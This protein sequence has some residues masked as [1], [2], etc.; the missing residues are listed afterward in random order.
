MVKTRFARLGMLAVGLGIGAAWAHNPVAAADSSSDWL[1]SI[2][3]LLTGALPAA[4]PSGL[5]LAISFDGMSLLQ[6]GNASA[7][8]VSGEY[9]LAIAYG[10]GASATAEGGTGNY[11]LAD[12]TNAEAAAG[13]A[14]GSTG[15]NFNS[16]IDIGNNG[17]AVSVGNLNGAYA[18]AGSLLGN[19]GGTGGGSFNTAIDIGNNASGTF[20]DGAHAGAG[21]LAG[22]GD[23][24][25]HDFAIDFGNN[26]SGSFQGAE[27]LGGDY[28]SGSYFGNIDVADGSNG[29]F[30]YAGFGDG[31]IANV[32]GDNSYAFSGG[33]FDP[34]VVGNDNIATVFDPFGTLGSTAVAG[35]GFDIPGNFDLAAVFGDGFDTFPGATGGNFLVEILPTLF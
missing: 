25:N 9:G 26:S 16:A 30:A 14:A 8:T 13:G 6:D 1:S 2:D 23:D 32:V 17:D 12:G 28:N 11:A 31:N 15:D 35:E 22:L 10:D 18:G 21:G 19:E 3:G 4:D 24:G 5:N 20:G 7:T 34:A 33:G 27:A 29:H